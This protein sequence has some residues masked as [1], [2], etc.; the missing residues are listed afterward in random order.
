[1]TSIATPIVCVRDISTLYDVLRLIPAGE[2]VY[3]HRPSDL[4][5]ATTQVHK[6]KDFGLL[7]THPAKEK[8]REVDPNCL[9]YDPL[10]NVLS[11]RY[12]R[13]KIG[14]L[15]PDATSDSRVR[16]TMGPRGLGLYFKEPNDVN[17]EDSLVV[18]EGLRN[19]EQFL[20]K[21][22]C[23]KEFVGIMKRFYTI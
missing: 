8:I 23:L 7:C 20:E 16:F 15:I 19:I 22:E 17:P 6:I 11:L 21:G 18:V 12:R 4:L 10:G 13:D 14:L 5:H 9:Y 1:M 2:R 3:F